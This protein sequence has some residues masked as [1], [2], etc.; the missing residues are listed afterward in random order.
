MI[1]RA[2]LHVPLD[3]QRRPA[4]DRPAAARRRAAG[5]GG[6]RRAAAFIEDF[7]RAP[8]AIHR[9]QRAVRAE[10]GSARRGAGVAAAARPRPRGPVGGPRQRRARRSDAG[11]R[12][13]G[14]RL[15]PL[16]RRSASPPRSSRRWPARRRG[17]PPERIPAARWREVE[18]D[19][20]AG[21]IR[22]PAGRAHRHRRHRQGAVADTVAY[23]LWG[24][25]RYVVD[26]G[27]DIAVGGVGAQLA[28][29]RSRSSTR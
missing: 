10:R 23:R 4:A 27:G 19:D 9:A 14:R 6:G 26:C 16:A 12:A 20:A 22:R 3:G 15:R 21:V 24:Y 13:R 11:R 8:V 5:S 18:V 25:S 2:R 7:A 28:R 1:G 29:T 17:A